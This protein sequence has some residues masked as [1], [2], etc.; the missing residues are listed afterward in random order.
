MV[1]ARDCG[2][3]RMM[4]RSAVSG[5]YRIYLSSQI[6]FHVYCDFDTDGGDWIVSVVVVV[7]VVVVGF[8][9]LARV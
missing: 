4:N 1:P 6:S 8:S 2:D 7:I 9:I 5:S 3:I